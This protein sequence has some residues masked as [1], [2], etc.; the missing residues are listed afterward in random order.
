MDPNCTGIQPVMNVGSGDG[1][2]GGNGF[3]GLF[4]LLV[5]LGIFNGGFGGFGNNWAM[6]GTQY[7]TSAEVQRGFDHQDT[8]SQTRDILT[9]VNDASAR[10]IAAT[11]QTYHDTISA[12]SDKYSELARDISSVDRDVERAIA[13]QNECCCST[14]SMIADAGASL[15]A[16]LAQ[17][18]YDTAMQMAGM[19]SRIMQKFDANEITSLRDKVN[20]L[21]L[22][23][24]TSA[25]LKFPSY[26]SYGAGPFPPI[27]GCCGQNNI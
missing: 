22:A 9:A 11:N 12:L 16:Q 7:A 26:W 20:E 18:K 25:M 10:G 15:S 27:F 14:K 23:Q 6:N 5:L 17:N 13:N 21:Q 2:W 1:M 3:M 24:A 4:G 19:E 8:Q